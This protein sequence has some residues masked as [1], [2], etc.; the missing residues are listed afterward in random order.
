MVAER[1]FLFDVDNTLLDND[2]VQQDL[3]AHIEREFGPHTRVRYVEILEELR[4]SLGYVDY[5][6]AVQRLRLDRMHDPRILL[7]SEYLL[8]YPFE[9]RLFA[10]AL[11]AIAALSRRGTVA[12]LSDGDVVVQ[13][14]KVR[15]SGLWQAVA[16]RV[17]IY[18]HKEL[19]LADVET[20]LPAARYVMIDDKRRLLA[21]I[22]G[23]WGARVLT[24]QP[25]QGHY[26][27][28]PRADLSGPP[29]D[30]T[31]PTICAAARLDV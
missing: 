16:G 9:E 21:A 8:E 11:D 14:R 19:M 20:R 27:I 10:G 18:I 30:L 29:P 31:L 7:V 17:L 26:A 23:W 22:K 2:T 15:R 5:L 25:L 1:V 6:G 12:I 24:V 28:G 4:S 3:Y 13:P